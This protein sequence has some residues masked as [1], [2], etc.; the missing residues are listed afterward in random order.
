MGEVSTCRYPVIEWDLK[1]YIQLDFGHYF[2]DVITLMLK[3]VCEEAY[4][5][6]RTQFYNQMLCL[7]NFSPGK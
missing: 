1:M 7:S 3:V 2:D 4:L 6:N 5:I